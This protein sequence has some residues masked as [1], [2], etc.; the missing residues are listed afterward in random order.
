MCKSCLP[1]Q[2]V[3]FCGMLSVL[4]QFTLSQFQSSR[5]HAM[6]RALNHFPDLTRNKCQAVISLFAGLDY[7]GFLFLKTLTSVL[8]KLRK[9]VVVLA[10]T[11]WNRCQFPVLWN[12]TSIITKPSSLLA[13][14]LKS[15]LFFRLAVSCVIVIICLS[16]KPSNAFLNYWCLLEQ[17]LFPIKLPVE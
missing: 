3:A 17:M 6:E 5:D 4:C 11:C 13:T 15:W 7:L 1:F 9:P 2:A 8:P 10:L 12:A 16:E 14:R